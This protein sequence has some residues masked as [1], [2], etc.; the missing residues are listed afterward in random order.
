[1]IGSVRTVSG[2]VG[3]RVAVARNAASLTQI[4]L[5]GRAGVKYETV[6]RIES[7]TRGFG[8][9]KVS[10][11]QKLAEALNVRAEWLAWGTGARYK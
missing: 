8:D 6:H 4:Q 11:I 3:M 7:G 1:M 5:A 9:P 10:V 2:D